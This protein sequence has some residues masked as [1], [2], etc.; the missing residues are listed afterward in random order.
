MWKSCSH[1]LSTWDTCIVFFFGRLF[2]RVP[3]FHSSWYVDKMDHSRNCIFSQYNNLM[4]HFLS[5]HMYERHKFVFKSSV[6]I[7][8]DILVLHRCNSDY[9]L[10]HRISDYMFERYTVVH[11]DYQRGIAYHIGFVLP[12]CMFAHLNQNL[13]NNFSLRYIH[14]RG[15]FD[16][17]YDRCIPFGIFA[18]HFC[19]TRTFVTLGYDALSS[20]TEINT[21]FRALCT[22]QWPWPMQKY[23]LISSVLF[24]F[25]HLQSGRRA[26]QLV[27][28]DFLYF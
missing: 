27:I 22:Y 8:W 2:W 10:P 16:C 14:E 11:N 15:T 26:I 13:M 18:L 21:I 9:I 12:H 24:F 28:T 4:T 6:C 20:C 7:A 25:L 1:D 3:N 19:K 17:R 23:N 5:F